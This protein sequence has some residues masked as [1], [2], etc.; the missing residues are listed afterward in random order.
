MGMRVDPKETKKCLEC[1]STMGRLV[2][3]EAKKHTFLQVDF[4]EVDERTGDTVSYLGPQ[5]FMVFGCQECG[6]VQ[7]YAIISKMDE[8]SPSD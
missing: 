7:L 4:I 6:H 3:R 8:D 5:G 2:G 1:G